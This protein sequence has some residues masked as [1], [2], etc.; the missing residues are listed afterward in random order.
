MTGKTE[1]EGTRSEV[2][3]AKAEKEVGVERGA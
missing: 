1:V 2:G 3:E